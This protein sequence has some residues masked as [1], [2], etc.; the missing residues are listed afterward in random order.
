M[1]VVKIIQVKILF[2]FKKSY[3]SVSL[4]YIMTFV[5]PWSEEKLSTLTGKSLIRQLLL[6]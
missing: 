4:D 2:S 3:Y 6:K 5:L 1:G